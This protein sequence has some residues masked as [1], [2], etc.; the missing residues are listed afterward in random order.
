MIFFVNFLVCRYAVLWIYYTDL[1]TCEPDISM[2]V[3]SKPKVL[4]FVF[5]WK[6]VQYVDYAIAWKMN[7][8]ESCNWWCVYDLSTGP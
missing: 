6:S 7:V 8:K 3:V 4:L 5:D 1:I 2:S